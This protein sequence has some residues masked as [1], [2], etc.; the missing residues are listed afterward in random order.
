[1]SI[2]QLNIRITYDSGLVSNWEDLVDTIRNLN[3]TGGIK[4]Y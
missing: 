4:W 2:Q 3:L 1:M